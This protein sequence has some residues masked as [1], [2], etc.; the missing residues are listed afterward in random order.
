MDKILHHINKHKEQVTAHI[1]KHHKKYIFC[2]GTAIEMCVFKIVAII[3]VFLGITITTGRSSAD[4]EG[5][6]M[7]QALESFNQI[8]D[9]A[10]TKIN[11]I[12]AK[13]NPNHMT[14]EVMFRELDAEF[15]KAK[16][17]N[18][19]FRA[20]KKLDAFIDRQYILLHKL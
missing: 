10:H 2:A 19:K 5:A 12:L 9:M 6:E 14:G 20:A 18:E 3:A 16:N 4:N 13:G 17:L 15:H 7:Y 8:D 1:H 11:E